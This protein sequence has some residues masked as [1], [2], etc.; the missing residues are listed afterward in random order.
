MTTACDKELQTSIEEISNYLKKKGL[1]DIALFFVK[2]A[3]P[4]R[5]IIVSGILV[6]VPMLS[7]LLGEKRGLKIENICGQED[8][9]DILIS[10]LD[11][12]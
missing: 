5:K 12:K 7:L 2:G 11:K 4:V 9:F 10:S 6:S 8:T 1:D 3:Y